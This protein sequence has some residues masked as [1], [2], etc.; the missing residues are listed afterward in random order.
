M[1]RSESE[2]ASASGA[3]QPPAGYREPVKGLV[4]IVFRLSGANPDEVMSD[5][6]STWPLHAE[7][8]GRI[9]QLLAA[10]QVGPEECNC[11]KYT[12]DLCPKH[13]S[14]SAVPERPELLRRVQDYIERVCVAQGL[15]RPT[16]LLAE[17]RDLAAA[18]AAA[19][20]K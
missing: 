17:L 1:S 2:T 15:A 16:Q 19:E 9:R 11:H 4:E 12:P 5:G 13:D 7:V 20:E 6:E 18:L 14:P 3:A 10:P 8:E